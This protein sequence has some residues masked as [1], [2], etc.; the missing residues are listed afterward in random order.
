MPIVIAALVLVSAALQLVP[1][2]LPKQLPASPAIVAFSD[3]ERTPHGRVKLEAPTGLTARI[4]Q[5]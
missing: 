4:V 1:D 3:V 2:R 5:K